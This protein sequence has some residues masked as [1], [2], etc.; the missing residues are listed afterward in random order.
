MHK[1]SFLKQ[2]HRPTWAEIDLSAVRHNFF[3]IKKTI[4]KNVKTLVVLKADA[5]GHGAVSLAKRLVKYGA[6]F[7][8]L[9]SI[10]EAKLLRESKINTPILLLGVLEKK[11]FPALLKYR[12]TPTITDVDVAYQLNKYLMRAKRKIA[13]HLKVDTG[14]GRLGIRHKDFLEFA[15]TVAKLDNLLVEGIYTHLSSAETDRNFTNQ[16]INLFKK[17]VKTLELFNICPEYRHVANSA[18][19]IG[20]NNAYFNLVRPGLMVYGL[21]SDKYSKR[22]FCLESVMSFKTKIVYLKVVD[23]GSSI[24]YGRTFVAKK[25]MVIAVLP[26]GYADGYNRLLSNRAHVLIRG[27]CCPVIGQV[28]MDHTI[29]DVSKV[30]V[31][32]GDEVVL[33]GQQDKAKISTEEI[34]S[35]CST[36]SYEVTCWISHRVPRLYLH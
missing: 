17:A 18:A 15:G 14:M 28:C 25:K 24:S 34:A 7:F 3:K 36:I 19:V 26:V 13:V 8:G 12:I 27:K 11:S 4:G 35:L 29:V 31:K 20:F 23:K 9:A 1:R 32:L 30:K 10:Q 16:Q 2:I 21:F 33:F 5:Y 22:S 6:D